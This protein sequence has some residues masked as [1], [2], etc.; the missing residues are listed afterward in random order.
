LVRATWG[1]LMAQSKDTRLVDGPRRSK[2]PQVADLG[3]LS[4]C[5]G[6]RTRTPNDRART[7]CV[8][9]YTTPE[10]WSRH[11]I[12]QTAAR[13][14][15]SLLAPEPLHDLI[16]DVDET[17]EAD[18]PPDRHRAGLLQVVP[19][20]AAPPGRRDAGPQAQL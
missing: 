9:D 8:A 6:G 7:C 20:R 18:D 14:T 11:F 19:H 3:L 12:D 15:R 1:G 4:A 17:L 13:L 5:S 2:K 16:V 10:R